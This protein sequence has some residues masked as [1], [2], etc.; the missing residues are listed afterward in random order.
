M[1]LLNDYLAGFCYLGELNAGCLFQ[2]VINSNTIAATN[3]VM[4]LLSNY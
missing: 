2:S 1:I 4:Q 3:L